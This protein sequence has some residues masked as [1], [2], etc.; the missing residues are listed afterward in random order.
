MGGVLGDK[1]EVR[2]ETDGWRGVDS[3]YPLAIFLEDCKEATVYDFNS[4]LM[5]PTAET[6]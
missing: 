4:A 3:Q 6:V 2:I 1:V 5:H